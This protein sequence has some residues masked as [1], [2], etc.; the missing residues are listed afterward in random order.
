MTNETIG[1]RLRKLRKERG[2]TIEAAATAIGATVHNLYK[3]ENGT[4]TNIPIKRIE[5]L[6]ELYQVSPTYILN[7]DTPSEAPPNTGKKETTYPITADLDKLINKRFVKYKG[8]VYTL[9]NEDIHRIRRALDL[10]LFESGE[11]SK[12]N[13]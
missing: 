2:L 12:K 6:A 10:A 11:R 13:S 4:I 5:Q 1:K 7:W 3:Y 8:K 9:N